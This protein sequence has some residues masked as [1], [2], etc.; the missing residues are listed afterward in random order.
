MLL[1]DVYTKKKK[2]QRKRREHHQRQ[3]SESWT[4]KWNQTAYKPCM[5]LLITE[6]QIVGDTS[7]MFAP[8]KSP[9][10]FS[11]SSFPSLLPYLSSLDYLSNMVHY[12]GE[13]DRLTLFTWGYSSNRLYTQVFN[14]TC[15]ESYGLTKKRTGQVSGR[16]LLSLL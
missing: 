13:Q 6:Y 15:L 8:Q 9:F 5:P 3:L 2:K 4:P 14:E 11:P 16:R 12:T 1:K 10:P 7:T